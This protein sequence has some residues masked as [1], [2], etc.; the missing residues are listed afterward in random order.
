MRS[1]ASR[2]RSSEG[3]VPIAMGEAEAKSPTYGA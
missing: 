1:A 3:H 2:Q